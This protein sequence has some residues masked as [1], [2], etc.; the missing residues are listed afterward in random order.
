MA[1]VKGKSGKPTSSKFNT[2]L[3]AYELFTIT[4]LLM[5]IAARPCHSVNRP[6]MTSMKKYFVDVFSATVPSRRTTKSG[7]S[8]AYAG[9]V[10]CLARAEDE[11]QSTLKSL[12]SPFSF[13]GRLRGKRVINCSQFL[14]CNKIVRYLL[15]KILCRA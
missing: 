15:I 4:D 14:I 10:N 1:P 12:A 2:S 5:E 6:V 9:L 11:K 13:Q 7:F 3:S 8:Q